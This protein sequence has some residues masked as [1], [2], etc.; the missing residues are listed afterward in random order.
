MDQAGPDNLT[1]ALQAAQSPDAALRNQAEQQL[2]QLEEQNA[3]AFL[4]ALASELANSQ[5]P[6]DARQIAGL[7][8]KN[9]LGATDDT[10][11][12]RCAPMH[13]VRPSAG[14]SLQSPSARIRADFHVLCASVAGG[15][16]CPMARLGGAGQ[17][18]CQERAASH[19]SIRRAPAALHSPP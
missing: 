19:P 5:K 7:I 2:K 14:S 16:G 12:A 9:A 6:A 8:L 13:G 18:A 17:A 4:S 15:A 1:Q 11:K 3:A 10:K